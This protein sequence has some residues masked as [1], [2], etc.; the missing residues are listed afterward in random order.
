MATR[1]ETEQLAFGIGLEN[2]LMPIAGPDRPIVPERAPR[3]DRII[4]FSEI[5]TIIYRDIAGV[6]PRDFMHSSQ[7]IG[8]AIDFALIPL[9]FIYRLRA[10]YCFTDQDFSL[11]QLFVKYYPTGWKRDKFLNLLEKYREKFILI[12]GVQQPALARRDVKERVLPMWYEIAKSFNLDALSLQGTMTIQEDL[13]LPSDQTASGETVMQIGR[14]I[15]TDRFDYLVGDDPDYTYTARPDFL[16]VYD[17]DGQRFYIQIQP[18]YLKMLRKGRKTTQAKHIIT[19]R[20][21]GDYKD[22]DRRDL[23]DMST[24][25]GQMIGVHNWLLRESGLRF[26]WP[27][28]RQP[29]WVSLLNRQKRLVFWIPPEVKNPLPPHQVTTNI[30]FLREDGEEITIPMP[31]LTLETKEKAKEILEE[32]LRISQTVKI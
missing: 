10:G 11:A 1:K 14:R 28:G 23:Y 26:K 18:D 15:I 19:K 9:E 4:N 6:E 27:P 17:L 25:F 22:T 2:T 20:I 5:E 12:P 21:I 7:A 29:M 3:I 30:E 31:A 24:P 16:V 32:A 8:R 13:L